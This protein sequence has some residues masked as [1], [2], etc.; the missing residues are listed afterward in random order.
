MWYF[1]EFTSR[2]SII[3]FSNFQIISSRRKIIYTFYLFDS[4]TG[5]NEVSKR[6]HWKHWHRD[7]HKISTLKSRGDSACERG[8]DARRKFWIRP[9]KE[10]DL[11]VG[12][13]FLTPKRDH[14]KTQTIQDDVHPYP[15]HMRSPAPPPP[16]GRKRRRENVPGARSAKA[17]AENFS[18]SKAIF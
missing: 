1:T 14:V 17:P 11:G 16:P 15:C 6:K 3:F 8:G 7:W 10:T 9:L 2:L 12:Q 13:A 18:G 5:R 4:K